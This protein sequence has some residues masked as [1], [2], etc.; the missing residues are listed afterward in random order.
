MPVPATRSFRVDASADGIQQ[1][2][3]QLQDFSRTCALADDTAWQAHV[4]LDEWLTNVAEHA[5]E[6]HDGGTIDV[7]FSVAADELEIRVTDDGPAFDPL[8]LPAPDTEMPVLERVPGGLGVYFIRQ[9]MDRTDYV[10]RDGRNTFV[11]A[12]RLNGD[13]ERP[14]RPAAPRRKPGATG[15]GATRRASPARRRVS[16]KA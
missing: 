6:D 7:A 12:K 1:A 15:R 10:R 4:A 11:F 9:L 13:A 2:V 16:K 3:D 14:P 5:Y 8:S